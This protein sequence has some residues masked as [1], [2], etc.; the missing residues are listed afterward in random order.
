MEK[1]NSP[2]PHG[3]QVFHFTVDGQQ[4][5][6]REK[7]ISGAK[8]RQIAGLPAEAELYLDMPHG[9]E[10]HYVRP[11]DLVDLGRPGTE[12]FIT[13]QKKTV[14]FVNGTPYEYS[15]EKV[16]YEK[17]V[18][19]ANVPAQG[20]AGYIVKYSKGPHQ[21]PKGL[22]SPGTE[23]FVCNKMDFNVRSTHQS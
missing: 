14:I 3:P 8:I 9:W 2:G 23:V 21:N 11:Q 1:L 22:M 4:Y 7:I 18:A 6:S 5:E 12:H 13:L 16:S 19:L 10:D 20:G 15:D 17:I